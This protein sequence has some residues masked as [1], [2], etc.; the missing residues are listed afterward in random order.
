MIDSIIF[1]IKTAFKN[2]FKNW[3]L[4]IASISILSVCLIVLGSVM[5]IVGNI[6]LFIDEIGDESQIVLF[7]EEDLT[8]DEITQISDRLHSI[9][10]IGN[11]NYKSNSMILEEYKESLG[12]DA[13]LFEDLDAETFR[14]SFVFNIKDLEKYDQTIYEVEKIDGI[15]KIKERRDVIERIVDIKDVLTFLSFWIVM[16]FVII[17]MVI[18]TN[19]V[20][21]SVYAKKQEIWLMKYV[22]ATDA[23][24]EAPYFMEG[25]IIGLTA[26]FI[27]IISQIY[28]YNNVLSPILS[29]L[30]FINPLNIDSVMSVIVIGFLVAGAII[31]TIG[32]AY[33]VKKYL[34]V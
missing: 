22:G 8:V 19:S 4:T 26:G 5:L 18:I 2:V 1:L 23:F 27:A 17:S 28:V 34:N 24:I 31:G 30:G 6:N 32:S 9:S 3:L 21:V 20:K 14:N 10:N 16:I 15:A 29:D 33:P 11:I 25:I 7:I 13:W 12:E